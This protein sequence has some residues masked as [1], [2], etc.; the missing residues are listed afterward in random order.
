MRLRQVADHLVALTY[1]VQL[2]SQDL[3]KLPFD[4]LWAY[5]FF[6]FT[7]AQTNIAGKE[8]NYQRPHFVATFGLKEVASVTTEHFGQHAHIGLFKGNHHDWMV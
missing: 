5:V 7:D 6:I 4:P 1:K 2:S 8:H 3:E